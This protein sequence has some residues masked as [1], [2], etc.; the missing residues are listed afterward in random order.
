MIIGNSNIMPI[1]RLTLERVPGPLDVVI[2]IAPPKASMVAVRQVRLGLEGSHA[3]VLVTAQF[4]Q[5]VTGR[6]NRI[7]ARNSS[8][9]LIL[10]AASSQADNVTVMFR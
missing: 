6:R 7:G 1:H 4:V 9:P 3:E 2:A 10:A 8:V 5:N